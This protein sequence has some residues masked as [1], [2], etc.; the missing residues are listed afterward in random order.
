MR[1]LGDVYR[2]NKIRRKNGI[3]EGKLT[4]SG[5]EEDHWRRHPRN[6]ILVSTGIRISRGIFQSESEELR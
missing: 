3:H 5:E 4:M 2:G 6:A 1:E